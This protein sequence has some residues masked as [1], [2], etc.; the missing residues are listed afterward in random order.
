[1]RVGEIKIKS[2][3]ANKAL[4]NFVYIFNSVDIAEKNIYLVNPWWGNEIKPEEN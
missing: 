3:L 2:G 4:E 1:M